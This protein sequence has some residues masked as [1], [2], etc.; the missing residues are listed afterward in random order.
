MFT[1]IVIQKSGVIIIKNIRTSF[2]AKKEN[3]LQK[4]K[5]IT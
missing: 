3:K 4:V 2:K 5:A 1:R